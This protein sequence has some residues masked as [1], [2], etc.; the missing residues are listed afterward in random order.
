[1]IGER[2]LTWALSLAGVIGGLAMF[3]ALERPF[4]AVPAGL[5]AVLTVL[6]VVIFGVALLGQPDDEP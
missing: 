5:A 3:F 1:V 6:V 2:T 4:G